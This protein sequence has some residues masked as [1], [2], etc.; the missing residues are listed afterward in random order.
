[1]KYTSLLTLNPTPIVMKYSPFSK[2]E[3]HN[4]PPIFDTNEQRVYNTSKFA[5]CTFS[6]PKYRSFGHFIFN[7]DNWAR[8]VSPGSRVATYDFTASI[9]AILT[10]YCTHGKD[11]PSLQRKMSAIR[12]R[13]ICNRLPKSVSKRKHQATRM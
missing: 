8:Y 3:L 1:M 9:K 5:V 6:L 12:S 7:S 10:K 13:S 11:L 4:T 2:L